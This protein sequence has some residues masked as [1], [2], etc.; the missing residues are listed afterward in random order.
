MSKDHAR[1][2]VLIDADKKKDF[3]RLC[4]ALG[5]NPSE[6][7]RE[8]IRGYLRGGSVPPTLLD[9]DP[10]AAGTPRKDRTD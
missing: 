10:Q 2:T 9:H 5:T 1:L 7:V 4:A 3:E 6:V 8:L